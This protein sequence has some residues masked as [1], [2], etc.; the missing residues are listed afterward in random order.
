[1]YYDFRISAKLFNQILISGWQGKFKQSFNVYAM[2]Y[3]YLPKDDLRL[4]YRG[5]D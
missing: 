4:S 3:F 2:H 1:M 5:L